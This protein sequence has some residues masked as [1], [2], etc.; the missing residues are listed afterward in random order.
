MTKQDVT[1]KDLRGSVIRKESDELTEVL[2][3]S[4]VLGKMVIVREQRGSKRQTP[5]GAC[6]RMS[7]ENIPPDEFL[8][9]E[10][11]HLQDRIF[12][13]RKSNTPIFDFIYRCCRTN[14][15]NSMIEATEVLVDMSLEKYPSG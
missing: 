4:S 15:E 8:M 14:Q 12:D 3:R 9:T 2:E 1:L 11:R 5:S 7:M 6:S 10:S 13:H